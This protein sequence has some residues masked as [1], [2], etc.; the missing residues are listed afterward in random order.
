MEA[1]K[2][3]EEMVQPT[4]RIVQINIIQNSLCTTPTYQNAPSRGVNVYQKS[5]GFDGI[6]K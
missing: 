2:I 5:P 3:L 1:A 4:V 6:G